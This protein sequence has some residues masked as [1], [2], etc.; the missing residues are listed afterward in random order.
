MFVIKSYFVLT[1]YALFVILYA[2]KKRFQK[3][4]ILTKKYLKVRKR[5]L[6]GL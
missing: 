1:D 2:Y 6:A 3:L 4:Y 5:M